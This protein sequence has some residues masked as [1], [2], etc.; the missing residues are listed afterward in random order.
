MPRAFSSGAL[1]IWSKADASLRSGYLSCSTL[2]IAAVSVVLP[3]SMCP[4]VPMLTCGLV[5]SNLALATGFLSSWCRSGARTLGWACWGRAGGHPARRVTRRSPSRCPWLGSGLAAHL[6]PWTA[7]RC[8]LARRLRDD[9]LGD[10]LREL[11]VRVEHH[12]VARPPLGAAAQVAHVAEHL[13]QRHQGPDDAGAGALLHRLDGPAAGV[14]VADDVAHVLFRGDDLDCHQR[15]EQGRAGLA[16]GLL[17]DHRAGDLEGHLRGVDLVVLAVQQGGL[18]ADHGV[19]GEDAVLHGVLHALVDRRD[20]LPRDA[21]TGDLVLELVGRAVGR[22]LEGLDA[23][24]DLGEL[25]RAT[26]LLLVRVV[27]ALDGLADRLA[28]G[29]LRLADVGL[30]VELAAH[31]VD[32]D[33]QVE[34]AHAGDDRLAGLLVEADLERRVLLGQLL[35]GGAELLLVALRLRLDRHRDDRRREGHR[36]QDHRLLRVGQGVTR[37]RLLHAVDRDDL[38]GAHARALFALVGVHLVDLA[39]P[40]LAVLGA[41]EH[42]GPGVQPPGVH[43]D[44]GQLAQVLVRLDLEGQRRE[45]LALVGVPQ[46]LG[47]AVEGGADDRLDV[48]RAGQVVGDGVEQGLDALVLEGGA[49]EHGVDLRGDGRLADRGLQTLDGDLL[50][51]EVGLH[52]LVVEVGDALEQLLAVLGSLVGELGGDLLDGVVLAHLGLTAPGERPHLDQVDDA[53]EVGLGTDRQLEHQRVG[54]QALDHHLDAAEEVGTG[55]VELV[56]E[57]HARDPVLLR[58]PPDLLG[59][60]LHA[61]DAVVHGHRTVEHAQGPLHLDGEVDVPRGV[62]DVD[63]VVVPG[64]LGRGGRDGDAALLLLL[65]PVHRGRAVVDLTDLVVDTGVE[66]DALGRRG[67]AG[68]DVRHDPDV[69]GLGEGGLGVGHGSLLRGS[70]PRAGSGWWPGF[71]AGR[72]GWQ[73]QPGWHL[74]AV[75]REGLVRLG[76]LVGVL[77]A[78]DRGAQTVARVEQLVHQALG[79]RLLA[80]GAAVLDQPAQAERGAARGADLD[81]DLVGRTTDAAA[82]DLEGR[83][84]VVQRT[85]ERDHRVGVGLGAAAL[86]GA[87]DDRLGDRALAVDEHLVDQLGH[88][89]RLVHRVGDQRAA[90]CGALARHVSSSPSSRRTGCEPACGCGHPGCRA[91]RG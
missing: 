76:H 1:S 17:E 26:G 27:R 86:E 35:D 34:L 39:D 11:G 19:A 83:L 12:G 74:P 69:A 25:P 58:L 84:D 88:Q 10:V 30:D 3:W 33:L 51:T 47:L 68:V 63:V 32:E 59:L 85:L 24:L 80:T 89:R 65:H 66:E 60:R 56:D 29:H 40:L 82:A 2:V 64:A 31:A 20:V 53:D 13:R 54:R 48:Q 72:G 38:A 18:H 43:A 55:A 50:A 23:D 22:D 28:V 91:S 6:G 75:V 37:R 57:A 73:S 7:P 9:L 36:L 67:L 8:S 5:R 81:R 71:P 77:A 90:R 45:R 49:G 61:G 46:D 42:R 15:L 41:V 52:E 78:F 21:T 70:G 79:H 16:C 4:M 44:V 14:Q 62:D 87:V